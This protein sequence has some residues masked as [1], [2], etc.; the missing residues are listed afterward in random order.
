[1]N[2]RK[3][4]WTPLLLLLAGFAVLAQLLGLEV[5]LGAFIAGAVLRLLDRGGMM[6]HPRFR[7]KLEAVGFGVLSRSSS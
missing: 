1:M 6:T 2:E 3:T 4:Q 7:A 5:I